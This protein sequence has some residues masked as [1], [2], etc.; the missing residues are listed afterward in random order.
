MDELQTLL[1]P[2]LR[3]AGFRHYGRTYNRTTADGLTHVIGFQMG[4]FDPPGTTYFPGLRENLY[5]RFAVNL[6]VYV[7]E[8]ARYHGGREA[9]RVVHDYDCCIRTRLG[10][11]S[12]KERW[13][14]IS[15][16]AQ[17]VAELVHRFQGE[18]FPLFHRFERRNQV[19]SEF[20]EV[21]DNTEL[22]TVPRIVCAIILC[23]LG[24]RE[25]ARTLLAAQFH[26]P[27]CNASHRAYVINLAQRLGFEITK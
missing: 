20:R 3:Q 13:W 23:N 8:V 21:A 2:L 6:G 25:E 26:D 1:N 4:P 14:K 24:K 5:G 12:D 27:T 11:I 7:P 22:M 18:A 15:A 17:L 10:P 16:S 19:L 9:G